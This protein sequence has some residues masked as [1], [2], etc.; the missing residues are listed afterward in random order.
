MTAIIWHNPKCSKS[1]RALSIL[2]DNGVEVL[3]HLYLE[4]A[5]S[6]AELKEAAELMGKKPSE[7]IR[8]GEKLYK[9]LEL[10]DADE[11]MLFVAMAANPIL[12]ERPIVFKDDK[13]VLGRPPEDIIAL[14]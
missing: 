1:R 9:E 5:P 13:V 10:K 4:E 7:F 11:E 2:E 12:I 6:V 14:I 8:R 3:V